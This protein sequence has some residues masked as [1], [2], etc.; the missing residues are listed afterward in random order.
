MLPCDLAQLSKCAPEHEA[1]EAGRR[2]DL[3]QQG[4]DAAVLLVPD[5]RA[6]EVPSREARLRRHNE[7]RCGSAQE[8]L[9]LGCE[10]RG[11]VLDLRVTLTEG[12]GPHETVR[13][14]EQLDGLCG[15]S[16]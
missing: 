11:Q 15:L 16:C 14:V 13:V 3:A 2:T 5:V 9:Q 8:R 7:V 1:L 10:L 12:L 4:L 6:G